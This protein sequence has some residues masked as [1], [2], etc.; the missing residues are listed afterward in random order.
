MKQKLLAFLQY[1]LEVEEKSIQKFKKN[2]DENYAHA[3]SW[4]T[5]VFAAAAA[6]KV[7]KY[8]MA[9]VESVQDMLL[10]KM[11]H[12]AK[13]P[14]SS[15]SETSNLIETYELATIATLFGTCNT[16]A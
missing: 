8:T 12:K 9:T 2:F 13:Y 14:A 6:I 7:I 5:E 15:T 11:T 10:R 16:L 1:E 4:G 3:L